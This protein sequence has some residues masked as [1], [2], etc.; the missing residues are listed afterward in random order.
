MIEL[1]R[2]LQADVD[3][4]AVR[5]NGAGFTTRHAHRMFDPFQRLHSA[6]E[7]EGTGVGLAIVRRIVARHGG[8]ITATGEPGVRFSLAPGPAGWELR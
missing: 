2:E 1:E 5:D 7:F 4:F 8:Q 3:V 6:G